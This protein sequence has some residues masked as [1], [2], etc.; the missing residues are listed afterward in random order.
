MPGI[1]ESMPRAAYDFFRNHPEI[2]HL[3]LRFWHMKPI[4]GVD[5]EQN[6]PQTS[7]GDL[8]AFFT[9]LE[10]STFCLHT[11]D[12]ADVDL[13]GCHCEWISAL[14]FDKLSD[15]T[16]S[17]CIHP[18]DFLKAMIKATKN[19]PLHLK[20][21]L[22]Y[23]S[24]EWNHDPGAIANPLVSEVNK[25]LDGIAKSLRDIW[26]CLRGFDELPDAASIAQHG[27]TLKCLF[28]DVRKQ[29]GPLVVTYPLAEWQMLC[30]SLDGVR[31][32]DVVYPSVDADCRIRDHQEF[33][34][35]VHATT[36]IP[37]LKFLG[38]NNWPFLMGTRNVWDPLQPNPTAYRHLLAR[39]ATDI[40][41][42]SKP[43][44]AAVVFGILEKI[45]GK[46]NQGFGL[47][48][49]H[50]GKSRV[51]VLGG[52]W[53]MK[54]EPVKRWILDRQTEFE[55][56]EYDIDGLAHEIGQWEAGDVW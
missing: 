6:A 36:S 21:F 37:S 54:M 24:Q 26:I 34:D 9:G 3:V 41:D 48:P 39:L 23:Q 46:R 30:R 8:K 10:P 2:R 11:L 38:V 45:A 44:L 53:K 47:S 20:N 25:F 49:M 55:R 1:D 31:Q 14:N 27:K 12:L 43:D 40:L 19:S 28:I 51:E 18:Q 29:K 4:H 52:E 33:Y 17:N 22:L 13:R 16:L 32:V 15:L 5:Q 56:K 50:F 42:L 7:K 35:Y